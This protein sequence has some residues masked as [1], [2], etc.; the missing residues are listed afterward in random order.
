MPCYSPLQAN[1]S[2][3]ED[4][5]KDVKFSNFD[6]FSKG[7][8]KPEDSLL[9]PCGRCMGCRLE[10]SRQWALRCIHE[11]KMYDENCFITLTFSD[12]YLPEDGSLDRKCIQDFIKRVRRRFDSRKIRVFYCGEYGDLLSRPHYHVLFF[13]LDFPDKVLWRK[14]NG[15]KYYSSSVLADLW[16]YGFSSIGDVT[17]E[18]AAYVAR[19]CTKKIN[20]SLAEE[21]YKGKLPEFCGMSLKPGIGKP[22]FDKFAKSDLFPHDS[23]VARGTE[24]KVPRYYDVLW[25]RERPAEFARIK[26]IRREKGLSKESQFSFDRLAVMYKCMEARVKKLIRT[27][28]SVN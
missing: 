22:W 10:R 15:S 16:P 23:C 20:G 2:L 17:F 26:E 9:L 11:A 19:Y 24:C 27:V 3:R 13:N 1:F 8:S 5:K 28:E 18:S 6:W 12:D 21:H 7:L 25:E 4:G 14:V